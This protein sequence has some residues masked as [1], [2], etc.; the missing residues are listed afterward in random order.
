MSSTLGP[1][2]GNGI[3]GNPYPAALGQTYS[4]WMAVTHRRVLLVDDHP[5][6]LRS[7]RAWLTHEGY[8]IVGTATTGRQGAQRAIELA[9]DVVLLDV[10]LPDHS[11][12]D[13]AFE[14]AAHEPRPAV[15]LISSD[16][17]AGDDSLVR[18]A[19]VCGFLAK[20]D[21]ACDAI[22]ALLP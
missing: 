4:A 5:E 17:A 9:P 11:G 21:L 2:A 1:A 10:H 16:S 12:I 18:E 6:F 13:I 7:M 20:R 8:D 15:I 14:L 19:P 22:D 3:R